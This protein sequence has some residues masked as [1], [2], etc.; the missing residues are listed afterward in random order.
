MAEVEGGGQRD[1]HS[2]IDRFQRIGCIA[3][4][5][6]AQCEVQRLIG[7]GLTR[8]AVGD[9]EAHAHAFGFLDGLP[10]RCLKRIDIER[11]DDLRELSKIEARIAQI[12]LLSKE[13]ARLSGRD[14]KTVHG[15]DP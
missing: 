6:H 14:G 3:Y 9:E 13:D 15:V 8:Q 11:S 10:Q 5:D 2:A 4:I 7:N 12:E 1:L